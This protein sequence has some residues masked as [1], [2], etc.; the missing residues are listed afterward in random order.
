MITNNRQ[1]PPPSLVYRKTDMETAECSK[2]LLLREAM[3]EPRQTSSPGPPVITPHCEGEE[4]ERRASPGEPSE[5]PPPRL[6]LMQLLLM[7]L[8]GVSGPEQSNDQFSGHNYSLSAPFETFSM[9]L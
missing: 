3:L 7:L 2:A 8:F 4:G 9:R 6:E 1:I 5:P